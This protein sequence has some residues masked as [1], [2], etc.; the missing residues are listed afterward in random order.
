M[1]I[2]TWIKIKL[3]PDSTRLGESITLQC[4][5]QKLKTLFLALKMRSGLSIFVVRSAPRSGMLLSCLYFN[6]DTG[7]GMPSRGLMLGKNNLLWTAAAMFTQQPLLYFW[8]L[9]LLLR[10]VSSFDLPFK[11]TGHLIDKRAWG[12]LQTKCD[13][14]ESDG[15]HKRFKAQSGEGFSMLCGCYNNQNQVADDVKAIT[16]DYRKLSWWT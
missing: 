3:L 16:S 8:E 1:I 5:F 7:A 9:S 2:W 15:R 10:N 11:G 12:L 6:K 13:K 4:D 14:L